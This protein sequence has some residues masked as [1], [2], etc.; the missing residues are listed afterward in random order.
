[1]KPGIAGLLFATAILLPSVRAQEKSPPTYRLTFRM[2]ETGL[3]PQ[4]AI[5]H[6]VLLAQSNTRAKINASQR[7]PYY[8]SGKGETK[9]VHTAAVGSIFECIPQERGA[10]V[11]LDCS[12]ESSHISPTQPLKQQS[13][14]ILPVVVAR[15][16]SVTA[17]VP[18]GEE[19]ILVRMDDPTS[20]SRLDIFV[21]IEKLPAIP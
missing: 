13:I 2:Q 12:L 15:Q 6:Y 21:S 8:T 14:G 16:A 20:N 10:S 18:I 17:T 11:R 1:M 19:V 5:R 4:P 9:E 3:D 7:L